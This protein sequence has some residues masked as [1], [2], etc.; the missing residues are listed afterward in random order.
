MFRS[1]R[2]PAIKGGRIGLLKWCQWTPMA[3]S[4]G[5]KWRSRES[6]MMLSPALGM[7]YKKA[8]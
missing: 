4:A 7:G 6:A 3:T 8:Y 1:N 2:L 5:A